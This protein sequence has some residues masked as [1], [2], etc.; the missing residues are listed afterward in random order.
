MPAV[1]GM[2]AYVC[3]AVYESNQS[4]VSLCS[5]GFSFFLE[6]LLVRAERRIAGKARPPAREPVPL[7]Y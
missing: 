4:V 7:R 6:Y 3:S 2:D 1:I 5:L